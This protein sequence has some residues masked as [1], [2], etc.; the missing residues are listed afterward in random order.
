[1]NWTKGKHKSWKATSFPIHSFVSTALRQLKIHFH[2]WNIWIQTILQKQQ[3]RQR[4]LPSSPESSL[5]CGRT[6]I[7][8]APVHPTHKCLLALVLTTHPD[9]SRR[10]R[11]ISPL[12]VITAFNSAP[13]FSEIF[14]F[15]LRFNCLNGDVSITLFPFPSFGIKGNDED[16]VSL[17][18]RDDDDD[19]GADDDNDAI[20][21]LKD[22][23]A[24]IT[25]CCVAALIALHPVKKQNRK[26]TD[27]DGCVFHYDYVYVLMWHT[28][29]R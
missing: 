13:S 10:L 15:E 8:F 5:Q 9:V 19:D 6:S 18:N 1:M 29:V 25:S 23:T 24:I 20:P 12:P 11:R 28:V 21:W 17:R 14:I 22:K 2:F 16:C 7:T 26:L 4:N 3:Q 27:D